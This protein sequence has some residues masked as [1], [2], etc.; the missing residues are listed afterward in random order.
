MKK[1]L[2]KLWFIPITVRPVEVTIHSDRRLA[3]EVLTAWG[4]TK[5]GDK[6]AARVMREQDK[7]QLIEFHTPIMSMLGVN[8]VARTLERVVVTEPKHISFEGVEGIVPRM[9]CQF[10]IDE[11]GDC[12][13]F[14]YE[15]EFAI[16]GSVFGWIFGVTFV[17]LAMH[18][19]M[20]KH[21]LEIKETIEKRAS[22]SRVYPQ[23]DC[24]SSEGAEQVTATVA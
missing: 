24:P 14:R 5:V 4:T 8:Y 13:R 9:I 2:E 15:T 7:G 16:H 3:C 12:T 11:W 19:M 17:R 22:R 6:P 23:K 21:S 20:K 1:F 10:H 18:S